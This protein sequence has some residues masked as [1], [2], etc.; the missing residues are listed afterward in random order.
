MAPKAFS[1]L[2]QI[3]L[4]VV[5]LLLLLSLSFLIYMK[6]PKFGRK[7]SGERLALIKKLPN[8]KG[9]KFINLKY[10]PEL[11]EGN[12]MLGVTYDYIFYKGKRR[13]PTGVIPSLKTDLLKLPADKDVLVWFGHSSYFIQIDRM[14]ILVDPVFSGNAS[15]IPGTVK[16]FEGTDRYTAN[17]FPPIDYLF[18]SHDHYDHVD[19]PTLIGLKSKIKKV[20]CGLGV[21]AHFE[22]WGYPAQNIIEKDWNDTIELGEGFTAYTTPARHFSGRGF[23]RNNTL[24]LSYVLQTPQ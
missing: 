16:S 11:T 23:T 7:P 21:G 4:G 5:I 9:S 8:Y 12:T 24:W 3:F 6:H 14:R 13:R 17:D 1:I 15:P 19:Y 2:K 10:T 18:I 22:H 20:V